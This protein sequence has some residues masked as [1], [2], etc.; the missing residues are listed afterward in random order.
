MLRAF[1]A[2]AFLPDP[3]ANGR[4]GTV[5]WALSLVREP[6]GGTPTQETAASGKFLGNGIAQGLDE[7]FRMAS[8]IASAKTCDVGDGNM[9]TM[10]VHGPDGWACPA[11]DPFHDG[12][13]VVPG[14]ECPWTHGDGPMDETVR[15]A[16]AACHRR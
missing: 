9:E 10:A 4:T 3:M 12:I 11:G 6:D 1:I 16:E 2:G 13:D 5:G 14:G 15:M 8:R 7:A